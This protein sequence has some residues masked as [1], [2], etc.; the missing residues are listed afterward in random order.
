MVSSALKR[1]AAH[2]KTCQF[3]Q[4]LGCSLVLSSLTDTHTRH[5]PVFRCTTS[6]LIRHQFLPNRPPS[7]PPAFCWVANPISSFLTSPSSW[8]PRFKLNSSNYGEHRFQCFSMVASLWWDE[9]AWVTHLLVLDMHAPHPHLVSLEI[10]HA[11]I[12]LELIARAL[13]TKQDHRDVCVRTPAPLVACLDA[14]LQTQMEF[15]IERIE[16]YSPLPPRNPPGATSHACKIN[17]RR[18]K[19]LPAL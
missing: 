8:L 12:Q 5:S 6:T 9:L 17:S 1:P 14:D 15:I 19:M 10:V 18:S 11:I 3:H 2:D 16:R 4:R 13:V 7:F